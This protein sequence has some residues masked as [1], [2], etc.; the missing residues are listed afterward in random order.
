M[1]AVFV[2]VGMADGEKEASLVN[3]AIATARVQIGR[4][5]DLLD[6][7]GLTINIHVV[8][9]GH[10]VDAIEQYVKDYAVDLVVLGCRPKNPLAAFVH[11]RTGYKIL[12]SVQCN[13]FV[14]HAP[15]ASAARVPAVTAAVVA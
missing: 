3:T 4:L 7:T 8:A 6:T 2:D 5:L 15:L 12:T 9:S 13:V 1:S 10:P 11:G 14:V